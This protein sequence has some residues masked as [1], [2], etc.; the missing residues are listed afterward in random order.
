MKQYIQRRLQLLF[1]AA[2]DF[3]PPIKAPTKPEVF[4]SERTPFASKLPK[5]VSGTVAPH[6]AKSINFGYHP[7]SSEV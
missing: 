3:I 6:P 4:T 7:K 2:A 1:R 5:P